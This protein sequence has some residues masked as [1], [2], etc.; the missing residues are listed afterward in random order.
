[1]QS[2][3]T[4]LV[5]LICFP[6]CDIL[7]RFSRLQNSTGSSWQRSSR[8]SDHAWAWSRGYHCVFKVLCHRSFCGM[9][10]TAWWDLLDCA[11][12]VWKRVPGAPGIR[13]TQGQLTCFREGSAFERL[14]RLAILYNKKKPVVWRVDRPCGNVTAYSQGFYKN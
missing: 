12:A 10:H 1:M 7:L 4:W 14:N 2:Y 13:S 3:A 6:F 9:F 5:M 8:C 11:Q